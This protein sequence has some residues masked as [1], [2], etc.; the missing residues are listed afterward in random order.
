ME[1]LT[2]IMLIFTINVPGGSVDIWFPTKNMAAC[3]KMAAVVAENV[4]GFV[5]S[6][7]IAFSDLDDSA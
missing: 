5:E 2:A 7:C 3:E 1:F 4:V 6:E